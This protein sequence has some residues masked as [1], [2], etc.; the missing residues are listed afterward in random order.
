MVTQPVGT[1]SS[2]SVTPRKRELKA[3]DFIKM[4]IVQLQHQDPMQPAKNEDLLAQ[5]AQIG[6]LQTST[7]LQETLTGLA[8]QNKIGAAGNLIGKL[9]QGLDA[10][11]EYI[12][13]MV[14]SVRV[15]QDRVILELDSGK[16]LSLERVTAI[17]PGP[18]LATEAAGK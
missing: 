5:V 4:M 18:G 15:E 8:M 16:A 12:T 7:K 6:Q 2:A 10:D 9:V 3:D 14:T 11:N 1:Q 13:G 17:A